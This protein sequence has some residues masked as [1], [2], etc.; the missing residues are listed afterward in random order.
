MHVIPPVV[1][2]LANANTSWTMPESDMKLHVEN[3]FEKLDG[4]IAE[5]QSLRR[6]KVQTVKVGFVVDEIVNYAREQEIDLIVIGT[7]GHT[8]LQ[9]FL[10]GSVAEKLVRVS[11]CPVLTVHPTGH[12]FVDE[13]TVGKATGDKA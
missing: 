10:L 13:S 1:M 12:Q 9:R 6:N 4:L 5:M 8:G 2:P 3:A 7:H 11:E